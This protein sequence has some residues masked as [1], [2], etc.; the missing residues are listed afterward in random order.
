MIEETE[1][2]SG[3]LQLQHYGILGLFNIKEELFLILITD[4]DRPIQLPCGSMCYK[5]TQ[6]EFVPFADSVTEQATRYVAG[7]KKILEDQNF[8]FSFYADLT[9][10]H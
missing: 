6:V 4:R 7:M 3:G 1:E 2:M 5:I 10:N 9:S 8:Y